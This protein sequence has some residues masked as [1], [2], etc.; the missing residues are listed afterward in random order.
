MLPVTSYI[1]PTKIQVYSK[2]P[3]PAPRSCVVPTSH[4]PDLSA[5]R[6]EVPMA[7]QHSLSNRVSPNLLSSEGSSPCPPH[8]QP[9]PQPQA[10]VQVPPLRTSPTC[11]SFFEDPSS[12]CYP[13][14][15]LEFLSKALTWHF[16]EVHC[17]PSRG[18]QKDNEGE[19]GQFWSLQ[20]RPTA[21]DSGTK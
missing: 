17:V 1:N 6:P 21:R 3:S 20:V 11:P 4:S 8:M 18:A 13:Q 9:H 12:W 2:C 14:N 19:K 16:S 10:C 7:V 15:I 5:A